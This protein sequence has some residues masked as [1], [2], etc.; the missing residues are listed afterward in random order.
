M[1]CFA[2]L[3]PPLSAVLLA[4]APF[5]STPFPV[6]LSGVGNGLCPFA[7]SSLAIPSSLGPQARS[8]CNDKP[9]CLMLRKGP[10]ITIYKC[11]HFNLN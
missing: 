9:K 4:P 6:P 11:T 10:L 2:S 3:D 8:T 5:F 7:A 1:C